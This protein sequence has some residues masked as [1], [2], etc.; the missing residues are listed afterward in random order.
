MTP[1]QVYLNKFVILIRLCRI[2]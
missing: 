2:T 1:E